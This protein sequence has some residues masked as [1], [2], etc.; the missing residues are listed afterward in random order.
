M[1]YTPDESTFA[2]LA[3][4]HDIVP[5]YRQL[6]ADHLT[7][8]AAFE[9][10]GRDEPN[11]FLLESVVG[12]TNV[13]RYSFIATRPSFVYTARDGVA[14]TTSDGK[15]QQSHRTQDP[16]RDLAAP[17]FAAGCGSF[18]R[19]PG[20]PDFTGGLVGYVGYDT[21]RYYERDK[22]GLRPVYTEASPGPPAVRPVDDRGSPDAC[23]GL[24]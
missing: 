10:L 16:F 1:R 24:Y 12:G 22:L 20:L 13:G 7:P 5:V 15:P 2:R 18:A 9:L 19:I 6:L 8:V 4:D 21:A 14:T 23:L 11:A 3:D 17:L